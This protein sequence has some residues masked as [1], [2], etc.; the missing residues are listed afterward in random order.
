MPNELPAEFNEDAASLIWN[1]SNNSICSKIDSVFT[2]CDTDID[3]L[4]EILGIPWEGSKSIPFGNSVP[5]LGF[6]WNLSTCTVS[7]MEGKKAKYKAVVKEWS[8]KLIHTLDEVQRLYGKLLHISLVIPAGCAYLTS[9][10]SMLELFTSNPFVPHHPSRDMAKDL[11]WWLDV[12]NHNQ[13]SWSIPGPCHTTDWG[14]FSDVSS[15][16][17]IGIVIAGRWHAWQLIPGWKGDGW[18]IGWAEAVGF[19]LLVR[20][21]ITASKPGEHFKI[22]AEKLWSGQRLVEREKLKQSN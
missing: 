10:E 4:S 13:I 12:L 11:S 21:L 19:E 20:T 17:G 15:G 6:D 1:Y 8:L 18:D 22:F 2:Y 14:A 5:Y 7:V 16:I 9:L 3:T